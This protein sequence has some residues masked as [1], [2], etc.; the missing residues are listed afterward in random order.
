MNISLPLFRKKLRR[1]RPEARLQKAIIQHVK[2]A[3]EPNVLCISIP[4]ERQCSEQQLIELTLMGMRAGASDLLF[5]K[6]G[7][8]YFLEIKSATGRLEPEQITF[9]EEATLAGAHCAMVNNIDDALAI[10]RRWGLIRIE[11]VGGFGRIRRAP[12]RAAA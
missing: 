10:L 4:N 6:E 9:M 3:A 5:V 8:S 2:L 11:M 1:S 7:Q 12:V